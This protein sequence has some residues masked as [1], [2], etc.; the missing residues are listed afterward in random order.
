LFAH[1]TRPE[2]TI[3]WRWQKDDIAF[4]D[5]RVTQHHAVDDYRPARRVMQRATVLGDVPFFR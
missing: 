4:W 3:R 5:N 2:F 1:T